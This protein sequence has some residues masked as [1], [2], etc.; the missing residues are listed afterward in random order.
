MKAFKPTWLYVKQHNVTGLKYFGK[1]ISDP[2]SY[3]GSGIVWTR[4]LNKH[5]NDVSTVW[6]QLFEDSNS[7]KEYALKFSLENNIV[8]SKEWANLKQED[9]HMGGYYGPV[10]AETRRKIGEKRKSHRHTE[11]SKKKIG[12]KSKGRSLSEEWK[13]KIGEAGKGKKFKNVKALME[14]LNEED[15]DSCGKMLTDEDIKEGSKECF[16]CKNPGRDHWDGE[17]GQ[18]R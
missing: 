3:K 12:E 15:C 1:T 8:E 2:I 4:H 18:E 6:V 17:R 13:R 7:I 14:D 11:E 5:G 16:K 9:G 10:T